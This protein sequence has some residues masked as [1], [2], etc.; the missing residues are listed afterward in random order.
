MSY[1]QL[2]HGFTPACVIVN[3]TFKKLERLGHYLPKWPKVA[4]KSRRVFMW[5]FAL[6]MIPIVIGNT[7]FKKLSGFQRA[8][9]AERL[10]MAP[11]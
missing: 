4:Q 8:R 3:P 7:N 9:G 1:V 5:I 11:F 10:K 2:S 6:Y